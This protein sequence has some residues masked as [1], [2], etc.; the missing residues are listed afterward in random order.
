MTLAVVLHTLRTVGFLILQICLLRCLVNL[1]PFPSPDIGGL[2]AAREFGEI[3]K[4]AQT[5]VQIAVLRQDPSSVNDLFWHVV[6]GGQTPD[7]LAANDVGWVSAQCLSVS[8]GVSTDHQ[9]HDQLSPKPLHGTYDC[10]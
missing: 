6:F 2:V 3:A 9:D 7:D 8:K 4:V 1:V 5:A 10:M